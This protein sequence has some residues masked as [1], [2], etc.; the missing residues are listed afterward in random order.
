MRRHLI[1]KTALHVSALCCGMGGFGSRVKGAEMER[2]FAAFREAGGNFFDTAHCY[3]FWR[4]NGLGASERELGACL[5]DVG[6]VSVHGA[7]HGGFAS[8]NVVETAH[9]PAN[10]RSRTAG[11][12]RAGAHA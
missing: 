10:C 7:R 12:G 6:L 5:V 11:G 8:R 3:A 2:L 9:A 4:E 1:P